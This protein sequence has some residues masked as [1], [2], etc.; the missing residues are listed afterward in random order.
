M[1]VCFFGAASPQLKSAPGRAAAAQAGGGGCGRGVVAS[2]ALPGFTGQG[3]IQ[4]P[5]KRPETKGE[6][7]VL[8]KCFRARGRPCLGPL[9]WWWW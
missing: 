5:E 8:C 2:S 7:R 3:R 1:G 9:G 4:V 6:R